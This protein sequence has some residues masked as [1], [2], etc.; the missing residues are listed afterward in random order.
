M[1][2]AIRAAAFDRFIVYSSSVRQFSEI[3]PF[4]GPTPN[5]S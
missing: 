5:Q 3:F 1:G 2:K 4:F